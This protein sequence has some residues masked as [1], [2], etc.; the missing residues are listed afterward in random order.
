MFL[1]QRFCDFIHSFETFRN[2]NKV[3]TVSENLLRHNQAHTTRCVGDERVLT[4]QIVHEGTVRPCQCEQEYGSHYTN[5]NSY[6][7]GFPYCHGL[8]PVLLQ[9]A[10]PSQ[11]QITGSRRVTQV[12]TREQPR[13]RS[14]RCNKNLEPKFNPS[15]RNDTNEERLTRSSRGEEVS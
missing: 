6:R 11:A 10:L 7:T 3:D 5:D 9:S 12:K 4:W 15:P 14:R 1:Q 13:R 2:E 8:R